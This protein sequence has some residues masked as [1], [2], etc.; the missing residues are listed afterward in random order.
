[1]TDASVVARL[2][3]L[4]EMFE[5]TVVDLHRRLAEEM[6]Q[7]D[8]ALTD[9]DVTTEQRFRT[10]TGYFKMVQGVEL[11]INGIRQQREQDREQGIELVEFRRQLEEQISRIVDAEAEGTVSE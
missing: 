5:E 4:A 7:L 2:S 11:M 10:F 1:M 6:K 9:E 8:A 3:G